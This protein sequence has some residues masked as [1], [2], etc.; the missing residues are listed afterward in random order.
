MAQDAMTYD[1]DPVVIP[2][3]RNPWGVLRG[4]IGLL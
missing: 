2:N 4:G 1:H 3:S